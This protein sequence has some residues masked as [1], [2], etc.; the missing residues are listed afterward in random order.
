MLDVVI[1]NR[2]KHFAIAARRSQRAADASDS[3]LDASFFLLPFT[4]F[5]FQ[6]A[7]QG[8]WLSGNVLRVDDKVI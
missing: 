8:G 7:R 5:L 2:P 3:A 6:H 1:S 4:L